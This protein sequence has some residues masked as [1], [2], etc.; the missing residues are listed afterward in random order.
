MKNERSTY[1][2]DLGLCAYRQAWELMK[3]VAAAK[4][5]LPSPEV[6]LLVEHPPVF[7]F[8]KS[9]KKENLLVSP[10]TLAKR[11]AEIYEVER[12]GDVTWH[13]PGQ[14]VLYPV[15]DLPR[16]G[17]KPGEL[18][19]GL[20]RSVIRSLKDFG[21]E[22]EASPEFIGLW[23]AGRKIASIGLAVSNSISY[24]GVGL[25]V[26]PDLSYFD[27]INPCGLKNVTMTSMER[28]LGEKPAMEEVKKSL[29]AALTLELGLE[30]EM[31]EWSRLG[32]FY[33][34]PGLDDPRDAGKRPAQAERLSESRQ[35]LAKPAWLKK[36]LPP[37]G[38]RS[39][40]TGIVET[41]MLHT[42]CREAHCPN[43]GECFSQGTA[44]LMILGDVCTR[45]CRFCAV[46]TGRPLEL[47]QEEPEE[48][49][50]AIRELALDYAVITSVTRDD[51]VDG[52]ASIFA[53]TIEAV[54]R[55]NPRGLVEVLIPDFAGEQGPLQTVLT[56]CPEVLNHNVETV[57]RLY[58]A[59]RPQADYQRSL[60]VL[61][62]T[63]KL[64]PGV[65]VKTGF[66]VGLGETMDEVFGLLEDL[67][68]VGC[69]VV[70]IGQYL[71]PSG[72]HYPVQ[73]YVPPSTFEKYQERAEE[74][75]FLAVASGPLVRS[76]YRARELYSKAWASLSRPLHGHAKESLNESAH[77]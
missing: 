65:V 62:R 69:Q 64:A 24:H 12:G 49:A 45:N 73:E 18:V 43:K 38:E 7:T 8:G 5:H 59:V 61:S 66:M 20:E 19:R 31:L 54:R 14:L 75:G 50:R 71:Q 13:G 29:A 72:D 15:F 58:P 17:L 36:K 56:A 76:S 41:G 2:V 21:V 70:T 42:V 68:G 10:A 44:T 11:G 52:G 77:C 37:A 35:P 4:A 6:V 47:R 26:S 33:P 32:E 28:V 3:Q 55:L 25:N 51:L 16:A 57:S 9:A 53:R 67:R 74:L 34:A 40:V 1:L 22:A 27:L 48:V 46:N 39:T 63:R 23:V 30:M 60:Q